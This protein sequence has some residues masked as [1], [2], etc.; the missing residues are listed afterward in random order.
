M[1]ELHNPAELLVPNSFLYLASIMLPFLLDRQIRAR[2]RQRSETGLR[3]HDSMEQLCRSAADCARAA[4]A[5]YRS[6]PATRFERAPAPVPRMPGSCLHLFLFRVVSVARLAWPL[7][8]IGRT[9][10]R[11]CAPI[12]VGLACT[13]VP[14]SPGRERAEWVM[15]DSVRGTKTN[16]GRE[17]GVVGKTTDAV[18]DSGGDA[19]R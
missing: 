13:C 14:M 6:C 1:K 11:T 16:R 7:Q 17:Q 10:T 18:A 5:R 9:G 4:I 19:R 12:W 2:N 3:P 15:C 8:Q